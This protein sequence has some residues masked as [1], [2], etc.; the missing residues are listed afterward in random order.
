MLKAS[1]DLRRLWESPAI[2]AEEKRKLLDSI[3]AQSGT[4][5]PTRNFIA[6][7]MDHHRIVALPEIARQF[8]HELN[9]RLGYAEAEIISARPLSDEEKRGLEQQ[10]AGLTGQKV[11]AHYAQDEKILGGAVVKLGSTVYDG[12]V[13]GQLQKIKEQLSAG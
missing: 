1:P 10:I 4:A 7:L 11:R 2:P 3:A 12:S 6:V 8:E 5:K 13:R 9:R